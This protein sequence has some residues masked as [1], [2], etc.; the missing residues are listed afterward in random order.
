MQLY[1]NISGRSG[2]LGYE[3]GHGSIKVKFHNGETYLYNTQLPGPTHV[4][5]MQALAARGKGLATYISRTV[6]NAYAAKL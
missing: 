4:D 5:R 6:R 3:I 1:K 2:V